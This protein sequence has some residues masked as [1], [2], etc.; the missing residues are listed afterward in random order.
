MKAGLK[1]TKP[2]K[3]MGRIKSK[4]TSPEI[5]VRKYLFSK[6]FRFRIHVSNLPGRPDI[7]LKKHN[8][9]IFVNGC[10]WHAHDGCKFK[11]IPI[12]NPV[13]WENKIVNNV[14]RDKTNIELLINL[15]WCVYVIWECELNKAKINE[16]LSRLSKSIMAGC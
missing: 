3:G 10:F 11:K 12:K 9:A 4:N 13:F 15:G 7:V 6:G 1:S 14:Q 2:V 16:S 8:A 5:L